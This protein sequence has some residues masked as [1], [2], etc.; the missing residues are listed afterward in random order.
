[1]KSA[2]AHN[3]DEYLLYEDFETADVG[4]Q[5]QLYF[6]DATGLNAGI[7]EVNYRGI[8][9]GKVLKLEA[10]S[11]RQKIKA[12]VNIHPHAKRLLK[13]TTEFWLVKPK[14]S[15]QEVSGLGTLMTGN[16]ITLRPG[17]GAFQRKFNV[18]DEEPPL[19]ASTPGLHLKI[20]TQELGSLTAGSPV[21]YHQLPVGK[22]VSYE[23]ANN[24]SQI[25]VNLHIEKKYAHLVKSHSRFYTAS[26]IKISGGITDL[27][28][29]TESMSAILKGG[30][31]FITPEQKAK[32]VKLRNGHSFKLFSDLE[33]AQKNTFPISISFKDANGIKVGTLV[34]YQGITVGEIKRL[35]FYTDLKQ[36]IAD[37]AMDRVLS[38]VLGKK[39]KFWIVKAEFG[40]ASTKNLGTLIA[41]NHIQVDPIRGKSS[42][43]FRALNE[44]P[45]MKITDSGLNLRL[46]SKRLGSIKIA[47]PVYYRQFKVGQVSGYELANT[48]DFVIIH[49]NIES[50]YAPLVQQNSK[51]WNA[52][53]INM[54]INLFAGSKIKTETVQAILDGG[55]SFATPDIETNSQLDMPKKS[56]KMQRRARQGSVF[57]LHQE[58]NLKWLEWS[59]KIPIKS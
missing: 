56:K 30:I 42:K 46:K 59:P 27:A 2:Q 50:R 58:V 21:L 54:D 31:G 12:T 47:D 51:F 14:I 39:S 55:I 11:K 10:D 32:S 29:R 18:L 3:G 45:H 38:S 57:E 52:S 33:T 19:A 49:I 48:A 22:V 44:S 28:V 13:Q 5:I 23:L 4:I 34:K 8:N 15:L 20:R 17:K 24:S 7:T 53:G 41:G 43:H 26:G 16:Y 37:V 25:Q 35:R 6:S 9:I 1:M 40:L 36:V